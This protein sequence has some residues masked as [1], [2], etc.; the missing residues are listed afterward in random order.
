MRMKAW[1]IINYTYLIINK[2]GE[3]AIID[4]AWNLNMIVEIMAEKHLKLKLVLLTH[5]HY[6]HINLVETIYKQYKPDFYISR[7]ER[8][9][10]G[11]D[12]HNLK[13]F[14]DGE[15]I[16]LHDIP[17][18]SFVTPGHTPGSSIFYVPN[19]L[20]TGD[21]LF[22]EGCGNCLFPGGC[23]SLMFD[24][25]QKI[26]R[27]INKDTII[28]P[29]HAFSVPPGQTYEYVRKNN[30]YLNIDDRETFVSFRMRNNFVKR[31]FI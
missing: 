10:S 7:K 20:F 26:K 4:P 17:I 6:D 3:A 27:L 22:A 31:E 18:T 8:Q 30:L 11:F 15:R 16:W 12:C 21:T 24:S 1:E 14:E 29:S 9:Y 5:S 13:V 25:I 19:T 23:P 28:L 2:M